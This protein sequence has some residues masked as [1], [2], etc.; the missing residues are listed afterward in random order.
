MKKKVTPL[1]FMV[2]CLFALLFSLGAAAQKTIRGKITSNVDGQPVAGATIQL[3]GTNTGTVSALNGAYTLTIPGNGNEVLEISYIGFVKK[4]VNVG[5]NSVVNVGL[6]ENTNALNELVVTGYTSQRQRDITGAVSTVKA[7]D[8]VAIPSGS[9]AE[10]LQ[11]RVSGV[12]II[13]NGMPGTS[14]QV[15]VRGFGSFTNNNPLYV[16]D[17][18]PTQDISNLNP[19][20]IATISV[21]KDAGSASVYGA[22]AAAGVILITTKEG[23]KG[24]LTVHYDV[25]YGFQYPG[26]GYKMLN[27]QQTADWTWNAKKAAGKALSDVQ[28]GTGPVP[29]LPDYIMAGNGNYGLPAS[30]PLVN[31]ALYDGRTGLNSNG[32]LNYQIVKANK[33]GT[34]WYKEVTRVAPILNHNIDLSGGTDNTKYNIGFNYYNQQGIILATY[35]KRYTIRANTEFNIKNRL[36]IGENLQVALRDNPTISNLSEGNAISWT[37]RENPLIPVYD[38]KG[39]FAGTAAKGFNNPQNAVADQVRSKDNKSYTTDIFGNVYAE[40]ALPYFLTLRSS[41]GGDYYNYFYNSYGYKTYENAENTSSNFVY[42]GGGYGTSWT[43]TNT[44]KFAHQFGQHDITVL[45]GTE[46]IQDGV[47]WQI[48]GSGLNPFSWDLLYR[49]LNTTQTSGRSVGDNPLVGSKLFSVFGKVDYSYADKYLISGTLRRDGSSN[50]G[51]QD[52]YGV[53]P[54]VA[55]GWRISSE[56][57]M[58]NISWINDL[59]IRGSWGTMGNQQINYLNQYSLY[60]TRPSAASYDIGGT[61]NSIAEGLIRTNLANPKGHW[62]TNETSNIGFDATLFNNSFT[63]VFDLYRKLTKDLLYNPQVEATVGYFRSYPYINIGSMEDKGIELELGKTGTITGDWKY[64]ISGNLTTYHNQIIKI[65]DGV[66]YFDGNSFGSGRIPGT[67]TRNQV[68]HPVSAFYGYKVI[69]LWQSQAEIDAADAQAQ[70]AKGDPNATYQSGGERVGEFHY[71]DLLPNGQHQGYVSDATRAFTG[72]PNPKFTYGLN[73]GVTYKNWGLKLFFYGSQGND[74]FDYTR[75]FTD[76]YPSFSGGAVSARILDSWTPT[77]TNTNVPIFEDRSNFSTNGTTNSYYVQKGSY[78]RCRNIELG[79][80]FNK[81]SLTRIGVENLRVFVQTINPFTITKY[82]GLDPEISGTDTNF[83]VDY[84]NYPTVK[85]LV[86][87]INVVF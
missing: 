83:G 65:A 36:K 43:W 33:A 22:R 66:N 59:K 20:D 25:S 48:S 82:S 60:G 68:G 8:L 9:A 63:I 37:Y 78:F 64:D 2:C 21:L 3:K 31:P 62:E 28:Y 50:F 72:D 76:F 34:N 15:R 35:L 61:S 16:V 54:A 86:F 44:L 69:G 87:G 29:V 58:K 70:K 85:Q 75:W 47:G 4:D 12:T 71:S 77:H 39:N 11:G 67:V 7:K 81:G 51:S 30:S 84:G 13:S 74:I 38:I 79:Y 53:F 41:F 26:N 40:L 5:S 10:Q 27:P 73:L 17:G 1:L 18:V 32:D 6:D 19:N 45:A 57:F 24:K 42:E 49:T 55:L 52:K 56:S 14:S 46:A 23:Q 80:T